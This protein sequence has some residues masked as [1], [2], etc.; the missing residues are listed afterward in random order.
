MKAEKYRIH[1]RNQ[2]TI[3]LSEAVSV[4]KTP[5]MLTVERIFGISGQHMQQMVLHL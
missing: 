1:L 3:C 4:L 2:W 5:L